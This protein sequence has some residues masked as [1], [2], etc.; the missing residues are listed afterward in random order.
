MV[1]KKRATP[2][3]HDLPPVIAALIRELARD[4]GLT[5]EEWLQVEKEER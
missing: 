4:A 3:T 1:G 5:E 2:S